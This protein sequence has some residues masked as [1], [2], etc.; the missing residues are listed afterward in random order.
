MSTKFNIDVSLDVFKLLTSRLE[1][2][3]THDDVIRDLLE[4]DSIVEP[5][6]PTEH[7]LMTMADHM[8]RSMQAKSNGFLSR[9]LWL[10]DGT[11]LRA[12]Y[13]QKA[14]LAH[15]VDGEWVNPDGEVMSSP[16]AAASAITDTNVNGL[17]FWEAKRPTDRGWCRLD[18][19]AER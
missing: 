11:E 6:N 5:E 10:P 13:K 3:Q 16:S 8:T 2:G 7:P 1:E 12:R 19:L 15:I 9:N 14:Y 4:L 18:R 17:R